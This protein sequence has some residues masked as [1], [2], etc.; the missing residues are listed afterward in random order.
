[1]WKKLKHQ[2][3]WLESLES[4][5]DLHDLRARLPQ[6]TE[7]RKY[8]QHERLLHLLVTLCLAI[9]FM[10]VLFLFIDQANPLFGILLLILLILEAAYIVHYYHLENGIQKLWEIEQRLYDKVHE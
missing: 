4:S 9:I 3:A 10:F 6:I 2:M 5:P 7:N 8:F 1:M